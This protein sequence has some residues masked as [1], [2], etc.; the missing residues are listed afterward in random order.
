MMER[1]TG[2]GGISPVIKQRAAQRVYGAEHVAAGSDEASIS[3]FARE[4]G[5]IMG[6]LDKI[7]DV[8]QEK[9]EGFKKQIA[10]GT[11]HPDPAKVARS[12]LMVGFLN[13]EE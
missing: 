5:R 2:Q 13:G 12:L 10:E 1:I 7:P 6:E 4:L 8:R 9:I 11:Y 3:P